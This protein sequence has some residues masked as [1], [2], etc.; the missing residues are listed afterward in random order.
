M[1]DQ[2]RAEPLEVRQHGEADVLVGPWDELH[3]LDIQLLADQRGVR[4]QPRLVLGM[5]EHNLD[6]QQWLADL[7]LGRH[8]GAAPQRDDLADDVHLL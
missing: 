7:E 2:P 6:L 5:H 8:A 1:C 3:L 4:L